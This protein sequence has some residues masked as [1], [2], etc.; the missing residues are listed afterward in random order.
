MNFFSSHTIH[1]EGIICFMM[2]SR[3][4]PNAGSSGGLERLRF[5]AHASTSAACSAGLSRMS[6]EATVLM[7]DQNI[8]IPPGLMNRE[9]Y[10]ARVRDAAAR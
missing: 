4:F 3:C 1:E 10:F 6:A 2:C 9:L 8:S 7:R 5:V